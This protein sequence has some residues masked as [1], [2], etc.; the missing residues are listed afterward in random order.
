MFKMQKRFLMAA[1]FALLSIPQF[2]YSLSCDLTIHIQNPDWS[3]VYVYVDGNFTDLSTVAT[4]GSDGWWTLD[5][6]DIGSS[7][8][9]NFFFASGTAWYNDYVIGISLFNVIT[10]DYTGQAITCSDYSSSDIYIYENP[11]VSGESVISENKPVVKYFWVLIPEDKDWMSTLPMIAATADDIGNGVSLTVDTDLCGWYYYEFFNEDPFEDA[12]IYMNDDSEEYFGVQGIWGTT[13]EGINLKA[14]YDSLETDTIYFIPDDGAWP[15]DGASKGFYT[16]DPGVSGSCEYSL[17]AVIYD[18][19]A[20]LHPAFSCYATGGG[21]GCQYGVSTSAISV[22]QSVAQAAVNACVGVTRDILQDTLDANKKPLLKTAAMGGNGETCFISETYFNM[23]FN[24]T[25]GVNE[26]SCTDVPFTRAADGQW[27]FDSDYHQSKGAGAI[28]G[29]YPVEETDD[30]DIVQGNPVSDARNKRSAEGP[31]FIGPELRAA[32]TIESNAQVYDL[33]CN[34]PAWDGGYTCNGTAN[35][36]GHVYDGDDIVPFDTMMTDGLISSGACI[37]GW[38]CPANGPTG[39]TYY[40][41]GE[42]V[43]TTSKDNPRWTAERNQHYC[44]ESHATFTYKPGLR[45]TFRGDD[46]I[47]VFIGGKLAVDLGG[48]HLA[49]PGYANLDAITD[50]NGNAFVEGSTYDLDIFFCDR[51]TTMS[52][53]RIKTNMYIKQTSGLDYS[54]SDKGT[55]ASTTYE[56]CYE[57]SGDGTCASVALGN[58]DATESVR[59]CGSELD[60]V[61]TLTYVIT[62]RAGDTIA[63]LT[64]GSVQYGGIDLTDP[65]NPVINTSKISGLSPGSYRLT[66]YASTSSSTSSSKSYINFRISGNLDVMNATSTYTVLSS[67]SASTYYESGTTWD[68][69]GEA[70]ADTRVPLYVSAIADN[71]IDLLTAVGQSYTLTV[72]NGVVLYEDETGDDLS[73]A[74]RTIDDSGIDTVWATYPLASLT[75]SPETKTAVVRSNT[76]YIDFY[77]PTLI[78]ATDIVYDS[79]GYVES[80]TQVTA[81]A[82]SVDGD[83]NYHWM[84][85]DVDYYVIVL[86]TVTGEVCSSC[87]FELTTIS[88]SDSVSVSAL[89]LTNGVATIRVRGFKEY[90]DSTATISVGAAENPTLVNATYSNIKFREPPV[91]Y[92]A[93]VELFDTRGTEASTSMRIATPYHESGREYLDGIADSISITYNRAFADEPD[94]LPDFI[95]VIWDDDKS[96][97]L[98]NFEFNSEDHLLSSSYSDTLVTCSDTIGRAQILKAWET[99][100]ND[101]TLTFSGY[102]FSSE[103]KTAGDGKARSWA[104]FEDR[105]S[106]A[107]QS[108]DLGTTDRIAPIITKARLTTNSTNE[109]YDNI[110]FTFSEPVDSAA[111]GVMLSQAFSYYMPS[112]T[113]YTSLTEQYDTPTSTNSVVV[114]RDSAT[115]TY[116]H[117]NGSTILKTPQVGDY[118]RFAAGILADTLGNAPTDYDAKVPSPWYTITGD[119]RSIIRTVNYSNL[120]AS[121][122]TVQENLNNKTIVTAV[123]VSQYSSI[124]SIKQEYPNTVGYWIQTDMANLLEKYQAS[125]SEITAEDVVLVYELEVYTNLG[126]FVASKK[127]KINCT[128]EEIFGAGEDCT[129]NSGYI[130]LGWTGVTNDGRLAGSGAYV[131][132]LNSYLKIGSFKDAKHNETNMFGMR[133]V[134]KK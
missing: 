44:F 30:S 120:D 93:L 16:V 38:S 3:T 11:S 107:V 90:M 64:N 21:E 113:D 42:T 118:V 72:S 95:C 91:P 41:S 125:D 94:S 48:T 25:D 32:S 56:I 81:D 115:I 80:Y 89:S 75:E 88:A 8:A 67:D 58:T 33:M 110:A 50:K 78:F 36:D 70:L 10:T 119:S 105:G 51:R 99:R 114:K 60:G 98:V 2:G 102:E 130:Y 61:V 127:G 69:V 123:L 85:T 66:I 19:D 103:V 121:D 63:V 47:W 104:T 77:A 79:L 13:S 122:E 73:S 124:D 134:G 37:W 109:E 87:S 132:K 35:G 97:D 133:R 96:F 57:E 92:P 108:F 49:A 101:S 18:T 71:E 62:T 111:T 65:Y 5:A 100:L 53:V 31:I 43:T 82:D 126:A 14:L 28:G 22:S 84:G 46:D 129:T 12:Y 1:A 76:A 26:M 29:F 20:N 52:N 4:L 40:S 74:S 86:N 54:V 83:E 59:Y 45:F 131:S 39:W 27:E 106:V 68:Y 7:T 23:L 17:A 15:D 117:L 55:D 24:V 128:D 34:G 6:V 112:W 116:R 9:E